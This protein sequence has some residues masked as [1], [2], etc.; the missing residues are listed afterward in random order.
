MR[1]TMCLEE[2]EPDSCKYCCKVRDI[3][4]SSRKSRVN[5]L[6]IG[7]S[8]I[9]FNPFS[10][11]NHLSTVQAFPTSMSSLISSVCQTATETGKDHRWPLILCMEGLI[12]ISIASLTMCSSVRLLIFAWYKS[13]IYLQV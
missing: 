2:Y 9:C 11:H 1:S 13:V 12:A 6:I 5:L 4:G 7:A 3:T 10:F 8:C